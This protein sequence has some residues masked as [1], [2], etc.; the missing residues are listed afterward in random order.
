MF[1]ASV[2]PRCVVANGIIGSFHDI[3]LLNSVMFVK[4][5]SFGKVP[6]KSVHPVL[7][8]REIQTSLDQSRSSLQVT[9]AHSLRNSTSFQGLV[10]GKR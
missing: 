10:L 7:I 6:Y 5:G 9:I 8:H 4:K 3:L 2:T 1:S